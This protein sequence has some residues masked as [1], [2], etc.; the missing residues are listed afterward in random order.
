MQTIFWQ[1]VIEF[2]AANMPC[3]FPIQNDFH[4]ETC[5]LPVHKHK[6]ESTG[7]CTRN[8]ILQEKQTQLSLFFPRGF[9]ERALKL[10]RV[11]EDHKRDISF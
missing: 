4:T 11:E 1:K 10:V 5:K 7:Y 6:N 3:V 8:G 2:V 9:E